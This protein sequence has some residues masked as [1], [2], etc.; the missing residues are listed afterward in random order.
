MLGNSL[1]DVFCVFFPVGL[2]VGVPELP[3]LSRSAVFSFAFSASSWFISAYVSS[4]T[5]RNML[6]IV[7]GTKRAILGR[8]W[9]TWLNNT[10]TGYAESMSEY[11]L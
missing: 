11:A 3:V 4:T 6:I 10:Y 7:I 2:L 8:V 1:I 5:E 9:V